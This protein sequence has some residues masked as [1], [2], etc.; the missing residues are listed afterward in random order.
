MFK[1]LLMTSAL[2]LATSSAN[3]ALINYGNFEL[4]TETNIIWNSETDREYLHFSQTLGYSIRTARAT[5]ASEGWDIISTTEMTNIFNDFGF[6]RNDGN[7]FASN[8]NLRQQGKFGFTEG[9]SLETDPAFAYLNIFGITRSDTRDFSTDDPF[10]QAINLFG[11]DEGAND[12][13]FSYSWV[14]DDATAFNGNQS[15]SFFTMTAQDYSDSF[16]RAYISV[17]L[18]R[19]GGRLPEVIA[20]PST[21]EPEPQPTPEEPLLPVNNPPGDDEHTAVSAPSTFALS[22]L[23]VGLLLMRCRK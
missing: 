18:S 8:D 7:E 19:D 4:D 11:E 17:G 20:P 16:A 3:A 2:L 13:L 10:I 15:N 6:I 22:M 5:Y 23:G 12:G 9:D 1:K 21:P 14:Q